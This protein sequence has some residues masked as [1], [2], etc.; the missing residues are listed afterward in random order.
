M[1]LVTEKDFE[2]RFSEIDLMKVVWHGSYPLYFED[3]REEFGREWGLSYQQYMDL[4]IFAPIVELDIKYKRPLIYG[5]KPTV[6]ITY[7]PTDSAKI[8]FNYEIFDKKDGTTFAT[9]RSTQ[10]FMTPDGQLLWFSPDFYEDWKKKVGLK[11][12]QV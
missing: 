2:I 4:Q 9:A 5:A 10:V 3:A 12:E 8:I 1:K 7:V 6:R 11:T